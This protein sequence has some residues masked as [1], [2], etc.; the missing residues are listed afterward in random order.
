MGYARNKIENITTGNHF[1]LPGH[2][3][4]NMLFTIIE[5]VK[6]NDTFYRKEREEFKGYVEK[7]SITEDDSYGILK[8]IIKYVPKSY[9][10]EREEYKGI[11]HCKKKRQSI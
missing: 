2:S 8:N 11:K 3:E 10:L 4:K 7:A 9:I 5:Q 6:Q 1:N